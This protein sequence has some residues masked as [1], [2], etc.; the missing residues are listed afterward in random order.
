MSAHD[1]LDFHSEI[2]VGSTEAELLSSHNQDLEGL[3]QNSL[4]E[5]MLA[6]EQTKS[7]A[8]DGMRFM[9]FN[10]VQHKLSS[11]AEVVAAEINK[12]KDFNFVHNDIKDMLG[13]KHHKRIHTRINGYFKQADGSKGNLELFRELFQKEIFDK[14]EFIKQHGKIDLNK[15][16]NIA[17]KQAKDIP[18]GPFHPVQEVTLFKTKDSQTDV[19]RV[20]HFIEQNVPTTA[21]TEEALLE[22][23]LKEL[24]CPDAKLEE[25]K[26]ALQQGQPAKI[27]NYRSL[28]NEAAFRNV[29]GVGSQMLQSVVLNLSDDKFDLGPLMAGGIIS[30]NNKDQ[31]DI[32]K[33]A[34]KDA[35]EKDS[36][37]ELEK[38]IGDHIEAIKSGKVYRSLSDHNG[39]SEDV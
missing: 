1:D 7:F 31:L 25:M 29:F 14:P 28:Y 8:E 23:G 17:D 33:M 18:L 19:H 37:I 11:L 22:R 30:I 21:P 34:V 24:N 26:G 5:R 16:Y 6:F 20:M 35:S 13:S 27:S 38:A 15:H 2:E 39:H 4:C 10:W 32:I 3:K 12:D 36:T 9:Q